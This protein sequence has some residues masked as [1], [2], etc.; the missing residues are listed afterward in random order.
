[1]L[2]PDAHRVTEVT[3]LRELVGDRRLSLGAARFLGFKRVGRPLT[4]PLKPK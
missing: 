3:I 2:D 4:V 1:V